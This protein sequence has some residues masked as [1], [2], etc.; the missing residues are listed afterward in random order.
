MLFMPPTLTSMSD[1]SIFIQEKFKYVI[2]FLQFHFIF[3]LENSFRLIELLEREIYFQLI[4][5]K[6]SLPKQYIK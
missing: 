4:I 3:L 2:S 1:F 5:T 6:K